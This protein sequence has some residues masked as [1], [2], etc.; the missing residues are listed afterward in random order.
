MPILTEAEVTEWLL[1]AKAVTKEVLAAAIE[2]AQARADAYCRWSMVEAERTEYYDVEPLQ[3][4]L[5][6]KAMHV[7]AVTTCQETPLD[8]ATALTEGTDFTRNQEAGILYRLVGDVI[9][10]VA[11]TEMLAEAPGVRADEGWWAPGRSTV[12]VAYTAGYTS[13]SAPEDLKDALMDLVAWRLAARGDV[14]TTQ[15]SL[16]GYSRTKEKL[17]GGI[18]ES[19][20]SALFPYRRIGL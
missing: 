9:A 11:D 19:I 14:G 4:A 12:Y 3:H 18:P 15:D 13:D 5:V 20:A 17:V 10:D 8:I 6:L 7:T 1:A 16:D 2:R